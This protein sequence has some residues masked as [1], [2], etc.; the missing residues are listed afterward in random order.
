M[1]STTKTFVWIG[2]LV[3]GV[4]AVGGV[5]YAA[6]HKMT[7]GTTPP[8]PQ[9]PPGPA[10]APLP[11]PSLAT[12]WAPGSKYL[13]TSQ[14]PAGITNADQ[15]IALLAQNGWSSAT[16]LYFGPTG[17]QV[18]GASIP[19]STTPTTYVAAG[20]WGGSANTPVPGNVQSVLAQ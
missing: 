20:T 16:I 18:A 10:P 3:L 15:L 5:A 14:V 7:S 6:T 17:S 19:F 8:A 1:T 9:V 12:N 4:A 11:Q 2:A 13:F